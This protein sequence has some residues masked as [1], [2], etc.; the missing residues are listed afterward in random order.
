[1][2]TELRFPPV[3]LLIFVASVK[4]FSPGSVWIAPLT[5]FNA[6]FSLPGFNSVEAEAKFFSSAVRK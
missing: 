5:A 2:V 3:R 4:K 1:M 6:D